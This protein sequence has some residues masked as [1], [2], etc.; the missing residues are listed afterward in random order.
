MPLRA[1]GAAILPLRIIKAGFM[2][3]DVTDFA[4]L[5][6]LAIEAGFKRFD[7]AVAA[8]SQFLVLEA[9]FMQ[10]H[11]ARLLRPPAKI[12]RR[13]SLVRDT[14]LWSNLWDMN[15]LLNDQLHWLVHS[16]RYSV[17]LVVSRTLLDGHGRQRPRDV[18]T[19]F[20][21]AVENTP[22]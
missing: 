9:G 6:L 7:A 2:Q 22:L 1:A 21:G 18:T 10:L 16:L 14:P 12:G 4:S 8:S 5:Q 17:C 11:S 19:L 20:G 3:F 15:S 13:R